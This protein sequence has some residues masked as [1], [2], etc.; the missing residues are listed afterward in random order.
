M[1]EWSSK[2]DPKVWIKS[3][4]CNIP[5]KVL[6]NYWD[7]TCCSEKKTG[8]IPEYLLF[9]MFSYFSAVLNKVCIC[10]SSSVCFTYEQSIWFWSQPL[11][12]C[13]FHYNLFRSKSETDDLFEIYT[14]MAL[15]EEEETGSIYHRRKNN[16]GRP[17]GYQFI[18]LVPQNLYQFHLII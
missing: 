12:M 10:P 15:D 8:K 4:S 14:N 11:I 18:S 6:K 2:T 13:F 1:C 5:R 3:N 7:Y 9:L 16:T 17:E